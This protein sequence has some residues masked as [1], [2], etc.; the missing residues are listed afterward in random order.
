MPV[1]IVR[2]RSPEFG[3]E[4]WFSDIPAD[5]IYASN[6]TT[7]EPVIEADDRPTLVA[8]LRADR[9]ALAELSGVLR[10]WGDGVE[11]SAQVQSWPGLEL[12]DKVYDAGYRRRAQAF[13]DRTMDLL[14]LG[15]DWS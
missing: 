4:T 15:E 10:F 12:D 2:Q 1:Y 8:K 9:Q 7:Y 3:V 5:R 13:S 6:G 14:R 11:H